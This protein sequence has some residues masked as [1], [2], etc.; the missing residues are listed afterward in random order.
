MRFFA[1]LHG[2]ADRPS[3]L[4]RPP[5]TAELLAWLTVL[6]DKASRAYAS[7]TGQDLKGMVRHTL[8]TLAKTKEDLERAEGLML[9]EGLD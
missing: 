1:L 6:E 7:E 8:G 9:R 3:E 2:S 4:G 5:G